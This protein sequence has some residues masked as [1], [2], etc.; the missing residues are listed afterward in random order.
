[1]GH[2]GY[3]IP[4]TVRVRTYIPHAL[5]IL[6]AMVAYVLAFQFMIGGA[7]RQLA[8]WKR[9]EDSPTNEIVFS[10]EN[11]PGEPFYYLKNYAV[12]GTTG[13]NAVSDV[14]MILPDVDYGQ[15]S[16][17]FSGTLASGTCAV[18]A[19]IAARYA[20]DVGDFAH[21]IGTDK[22]FLVDRIIPAQ[23][24]LDEDYLH[25]G[26]IILSFDGEL[27]NKNY[28]F[29][30]FGTDGDAYR[31]LHRLIYVEDLAENCVSAL[32]LYAGVAVAVIAVVILVCERFL[33]RARR[34]DYKTLVAL[35]GR[36]GRLWG[37]ILAENGLKYWMPSV[38]VSAI[39]SAYYACYATVYTSTV[40]CFM[41]VCGLICLV[42]SLI[43]TRRLYY[44]RAK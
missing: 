30:S 7:V 14:L 19:N 29:V 31:S 26:I 41:A 23:A 34:E 16:V 10:G 1:M 17:Y 36:S 25:D 20:L 5:I 12:A 32:C 37:R 27:L 28:W 8:E 3:G 22:S 6:V 43:I 40:L 35:G 42:Y 15:N 11:N 24:G 9:V 38:V 39:Y 2:N 33:F 13:E 44:V 21:V 18:S 4:F